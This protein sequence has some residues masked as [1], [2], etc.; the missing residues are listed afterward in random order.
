VKL[1]IAAL[2]D[3]LAYQGV[4]LG[5]IALLASAALA[6]AVSATHER[7]VAAEARDLQASLQTSGSRPGMEVG[8]RNWR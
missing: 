8:F 6:F 7:I 1:A 4:S 3:R 5:A 2:R